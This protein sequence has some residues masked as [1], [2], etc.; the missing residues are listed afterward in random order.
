M[1][2]VRLLLRICAR[3]LGTFLPMVILM[4]GSSAVDNGA[5]GRTLRDVVHLM[6][7]WAALILVYALCSYAV[8]AF[9][10]RGTGLQVTAAALDADQV[11]ELTPERSLRLHTALGA[12]ERACDVTGAP[13]E[14]LRFRWRPFRGKLFVDCSVSHDGSTGTS[15]LRMHAGRPRH[16]AAGLHGASAFVALCQVVR[17]VSR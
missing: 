17:L 6:V 11:Y 10:A 15:L 9:R 1:P 13:G 5:T 3:A 12:A 4:C 14:D 7:I 16:A 2:D 8:L